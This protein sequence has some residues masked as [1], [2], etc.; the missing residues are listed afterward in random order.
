[1]GTSIQPA[2]SDKLDNT[3][4]AEEE[5]ILTTCVFTA[6][7]AGGE[8]GGYTPYV[9]ILLDPTNTPFAKVYEYYC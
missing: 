4:A 1:M 6:P 9:A 5:E 7:D 3:S 2:S 8:R